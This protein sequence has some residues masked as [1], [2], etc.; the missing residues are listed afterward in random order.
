MPNERGDIAISSLSLAESS[1]SSLADCAAENGLKP[2]NFRGFSSLLAL[3]TLVARDELQISLSLSFL[4]GMS[5]VASNSSS[6]S[7][8]DKSAPIIAAS[9]LLYS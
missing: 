5:K 8:S 6:E 3:S 1:S 2:A 7:E 4:Q 9:C